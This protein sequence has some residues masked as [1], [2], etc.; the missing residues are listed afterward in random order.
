[1][2]LFVLLACML[3]FTIT[4]QSVKD[5]EQAMKKFQQFYNAG[6]GDSINNMFGETWTQAKAIRPIWTNEGN[7]SLLKEFGTLKSFRFIGID[8]TDPKKVYVFETIFS[9]RGAKTTSLTLGKDNK[10][11]T[12]RFYT[13]SEGITELL[14]KSRKSR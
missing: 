11:G 2:K 8:E 1:M 4:A 6:L 12:F 7:T 10:L 13:T 5:H 14:R 3:P 9:K